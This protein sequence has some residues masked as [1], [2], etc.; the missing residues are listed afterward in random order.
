[1]KKFL[2]FNDRVSMTIKADNIV[3]LHNGDFRLYRERKL[4][5]HFSA[6]MSWVELDEYVDMEDE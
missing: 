1:M 2:V 4:L 3:V 5:G 6:T